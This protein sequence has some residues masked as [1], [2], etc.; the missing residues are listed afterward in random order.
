MKSVINDE[1]MKIGVQT[2]HEVVYSTGWM[3]ER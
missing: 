3:D 2:A 1:F